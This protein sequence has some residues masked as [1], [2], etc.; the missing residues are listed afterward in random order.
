ME[1]SKPD[2]IPLEGV[3]ASCPQPQTHRKGGKDTEGQVMDNKPCKGLLDL[4]K[5]NDWQL[6]LALAIMK[7][8]VGEGVLSQET[9]NKYIMEAVKEVTA[10][11]MTIDTKPLEKTTLQSFVKAS[12]YHRA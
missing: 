7:A 3:I 10:I 9:V 1:R 4:N 6:S 2:G 11:K 5:A 12:S 8:L